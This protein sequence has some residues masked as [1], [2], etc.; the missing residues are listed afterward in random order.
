MAR[1]SSAGASIY[2]EE[3]GSGDPILLVMGLGASLEAWDRIAPVLATRYRTILFDNRGVGRSD[4]PP[5]PYS[6][7]Q[8]ADDAAAVMDAAG[9]PAAHVFGVSMGGMIAQELTLRHPARVRRLILGCTSCGGREAVRAEPE[10]IAAL[11][12]R[13]TLPREQAMWSMAP[14]IYDESTPRAR[15]EEDFKGR[16]SANGSNEGYAAQYDAIRAWKGTHARLASVESP[17]LVI[18]GETDRLVPPD[19]GRVVARAIPGSRLV[20]LPRA[21]HIFL[22]DQHEAASAAILSFLQ[23]RS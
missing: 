10:V 22:T 19:N 1:T 23:E 20:M 9:A 14:Y 4:V 11:N 8:M 2:W 7:E 12:A 21:S 15:I 3:H 6:L 5:G 17:T 13:S 16:L 18:H